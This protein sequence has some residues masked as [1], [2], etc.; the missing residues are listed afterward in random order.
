MNHKGIQARKN[1]ESSFALAIVGA[2]FAILIGFGISA[3]TQLFSDDFQDGNSD[4][5]TRSSGTWAVVTDGSLAYR[6]SG[7]SA[8]SNSRIGSS[9]WTN[10]SVQ[11]RVKPIAYNGADRYA[12]L[13]ARVVNS[14][15]YYFLALQNGNRLLLGKRAGSSPITIATK[16]FTFTTGTFYTLRIDVQG[17]SLSGYVNGTLQLTGTD[18]EFTSGIIGGATYFSSASFDDFL[19]TTLP[20]GGGGP[21]LAPTGLSAIPGNAQITVSWS[22]TA[23][24]TSYNVK[25]STTSGGP[26]ATVATGITTTSFTNTGLLNGT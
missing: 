10:Y 7:T 14:N 26:Y 9:S 24:A 19:V 16:S 25:R 22:P 15:H 4:G 20:G 17:S 1:R 5:W 11:A 21:P 6:Q 3:Q 12:G 13:M 23:G 18:S 2:L 8:D